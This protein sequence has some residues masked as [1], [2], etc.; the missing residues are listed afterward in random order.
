MAIAIFLDMDG[1]LADLYNHENWLEALETQAPIFSALKPLTNPLETAAVLSELRKKGVKLCALTWLPKKAKP[2][3]A[4]RAVIEKKEWIKRFYPMIDCVICAEY[5]TPKKEMI[6]PWKRTKLQILIDDN[7]EVCRAW[8]TPK[9]R[10]ALQCGAKLT[11]LEI[12]RDL[13][14]III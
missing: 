3:Y 1:T 10:K 7:A 14:E 5:G 8:E 4:Q 11:V 9:Q 6:P 12:L 2:A 13:N